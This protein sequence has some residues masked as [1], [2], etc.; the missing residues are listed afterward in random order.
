MIAV[1]NDAEWQR[2]CQAIGSPAWTRQP[3]FATF[4]RRR[5]NREQL[6]RHLGDW[7]RQ[8]RAED[9][10]QRL[11]AHG[12][13]AGVVQ[14]IGDLTESDP[15]MRDRSFFASVAHTVL[16]DVP[17]SGLPWQLSRTPGAY[18][19]GGPCI[20]E[21]NDYVYGELLGMSPTDVAT[22]TAQGI[23]I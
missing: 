1:K 8:H 13:R 15:H 22:Y 18:T 6:D 12:V 4:L 17:I 10:M 16:G 2:L 5:R 21:H 3:E 7:T 14:H 19:R 20:G 9:V 23:F 11:Q